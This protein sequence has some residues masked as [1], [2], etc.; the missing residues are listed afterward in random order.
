MWLSK[1]LRPR[2][3]FP[4]VV[5]LPVPRPYGRRDVA[6]YA[7]EASLPGA[8]AAFVEWLLRKSAWQVRDP[9]GSGDLVP[10]ESRHIAILFRRFMSWETDMTRGYVHALEN[11]NI[12]HLLW[13][14]RSFHE[15]EEVETVRAA[16]NAIEWPDDDLSM[17]AT[18]RGALFALPDNILLRYRFEIGSLHPFRPVAENLPPEFKPVADALA[19]LAELHRKRNWRSAVETVHVLL[20]ATRAHAAFALRPSGNQ[21][22]LNVY[23]VADLARAYEIRGGISFRGFVE[24]LNS[25]AEREGA[26]EPPVL[27][28]AADGVRIMT[29]HAAKGLEFPVVIL[30]DMTAKIARGASKYIDPVSR[31]AAVRLLGCSPWDLL[32]HEEQE[33][34]RDETEGVRVAYVAA[35]R[36]R[37]LLVVPAVGDRAYEGWLSPLNKAIY[38]ARAKFRDAMPASSCPAFGEA[39]V[40]LR[41][42]EY[43]SPREGSV[44]PGLHMPESGGHGV[45]WWDP[46]TLN[47]EVEPRLG[48]HDEDILAQDDAGRAD[49]SV[50]RYAAW[51]DSLASR[52]E[53]GSTR[54]LTVFTPT[55]GGPG[56]DPDPPTGYAERVQIIQVPR[57]P[58]PKGARFGSLVHLVLR[59]ASL[60]ATNESLPAA[61][62]N[63]RPFGGRSG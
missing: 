7:I 56:E 45:V 46:A 25:K 32:D 40:L 51:K 41:P 49:E 11:R 50:H 13:G 53:S 29:V 60:T 24:Q 2:P 48:L 3:A 35:T 19:F 10:I 39:T 54:S 42:L 15:R 1:S 63:A 5:V 14:S 55:G 16:L 30:A 28:E 31:L 44:K 58:R 38:P 47:L 57:G 17:Y 59:D 52:L 37:D 27:E 21:V 6:K 43:D 34:A 4:S 18:L 12:P 62:A 9:E 33:S 8:T 61:G 26:A 23:H 36:A 22:L 20:D